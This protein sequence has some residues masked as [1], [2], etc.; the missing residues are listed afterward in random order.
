MTPVRGLR[1]AESARYLG[2]SESKF[3]EMV[4]DG[5]VA[6]G[7]KV[8]RLRIWDIRDLDAAFDALKSGAE[9]PGEVDEG[10]GGVTP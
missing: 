6:K 2:V 3:E 10:W 9:K 8:D 1:A 5:R 7:F 4:R